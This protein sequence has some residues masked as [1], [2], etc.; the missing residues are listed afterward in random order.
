MSEPKRNAPRPHGPGRGMMPIEKA[1]DFKDSFNRR[2][3]MKA[4]ISYRD[5]EVTSPRGNKYI[6]QTSVIYLFADPFSALL[7]YSFP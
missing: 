2:L 6:Q 5:V 7:L 1:K 4:G 3:D